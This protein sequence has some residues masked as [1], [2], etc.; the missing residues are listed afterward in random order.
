MQLSNRWPPAPAK[1][2]PLACI[3]FELTALGIR[4]TPL[5]V[6]CAATDRGLSEDEVSRIAEQLIAAGCTD[7]AA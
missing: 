7:E 2:S 6:L 5:S 3:I 1:P 4:V